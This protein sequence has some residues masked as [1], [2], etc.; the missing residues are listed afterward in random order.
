M[1]NL[2]QRALEMP[3]SPIRKLAPYAERAKRD[4]V[5]VYHLNIGQPDLESPPEFWAA[6]RDP[7]LKVLEYSPSSGIA[8][9]RAKAAEF[10]TG[11]GID[12]VAEQIVITTAGSEALRF[13]LQACLNPGDRV[14]VPEPCYANYIGFAVESGVEI[15]P[16]TT[17]LEADFALP[18]AAE[19]EKRITERT[20]A[21]LICN[22]SNPTGAVYT[23][24]QLEELRDLA[25]RHDLFIVADEVYR[26]FNYTGAPITSILQIEGLEDRAVMVDSVSKRFSLCG[27]RIGF[28]ASRRA[29]LI[30]AVGKFAMARL[31][32]PTLEQLGVLASLDLGADYYSG[33]RE[34]YLARRDALVGG[35]A[36]IP[37]AQAP[38]IDGAFYAMVRLPIDDSDAFCQWLLE[39]FRHD[40][41]TVMLSP[42]TGFYVTPGLGRDEVRIAYVLNREDLAKALTCLQ[43]ALERYPGR[44]LVAV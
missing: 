30:E 3:P 8:P 18:S 42:G 34:E 11:L 9:L 21:I 32:P 19:F 39:S 29:D 37:G 5:H 12:L 36:A 31:A 17:V 4:G 22:P 1:P 41:A 23:R 25:I 43:V 38:R 15:D 28:F 44:T 2:S 20:K 33:V 35:I 7:Q 26:D 16:I 14:I 24:A 40:G 13:A 10:Y 6:V 27:A